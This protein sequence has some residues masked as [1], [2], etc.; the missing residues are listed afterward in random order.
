MATPKKLC[1]VHAQADTVQVGELAKRLQPLENRGD[2]ILWHLACVPAG[3]S[4]PKNFQAFF[5]E[6][7]AVLI[8]ISPDLWAEDGLYNL[9]RQQTN[10]PRII[11]VLARSVVWD[12]D[13]FLKKHAK[14]LLPVTRQPMPTDDPARQDAWFSA[15]VDG[16]TVELGLRVLE[17]S[18]SPE[19]WK[20]WPFWAWAIPVLIS[21]VGLFFAYPSYK[22]D[23]QEIEAR[24]AARNQSTPPPDPGCGFPAQ[25]DSTH[26]YVLITRFEDY[27]N[28]NTTECYGRGIESRIDLVKNRE[29][30]PIKFCYV[31][32]LS[33]NQSDEAARLR[34]R[35]HADLVI[36]GKLR[37]AS[38]DCRADG[39][40]LNYQP[41]DTL[42]RYAGGQ[43]PKK[44]DNEYMLDVTATDL[45]EGM[46]NLGEESFDSWLLSM[47]N[48]KVGKQK[49]AFYRIAADWPAVRKAMEYGKRAEMYFALGLWNNTI[50][51][52]S[53]CI[54][55]KPEFIYYYKRGVAKANL[56]QNSEAIEDFNQA[57]LYKKDDTN[58]L[59]N[60]GKGNWMMGREEDAI[61]DLNR[62]IELD[63]NYSLAYNLRGVIKD[64]TGNI[65]AA[66]LDYNKAIRLNPNYAYAYVNRGAAKIAIGQIQE[67]IDDY[68]LAINLDPNNATAFNNRA[69]AKNQLGF[70]IEA[71]QDYDKAIQF[72][73]NDPWFYF[74]RGMTKIK[75]GYYQGA[76]DDLDKTLEM[77]STNGPALINRGFA[78][79]KIKLYQE[80][81]LD[82]NKA[83]RLNSKKADAY[84][85]RGVTYINLD[86]PK[87]AIAD[88]SK[89]IE[90]DSSNALIF[91][92]RGML[93]IGFGNYELAISDFNKAI[94][95]DP[96]SALC[97]L[98]RGVAKNKLGQYR[99]SIPDFNQAIRLYP[100]YID[101]YTNR[102]DAYRKL[103]R[104]PQAWLD[105]F[106]VF[107]L[108]RLPGWRLYVIFSPLI[109]LGLLYYFRKRV[110]S[111]LRWFRQKQ[112]K[113]IFRKKQLR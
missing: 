66:I 29:N 53:Q 113:R 80:A 56:G 59:Y 27:S 95:L 41:S 100:T 5:A 89:A 71:I 4:I 75:L 42:I 7:D 68:N 101:A 96:N 55:L 109:L 79:G 83:I 57:G 82:L 65:Q 99:N 30:L 97:L 1:I 38:A 26:L 21:L 107:H 28:E 17:T 78:K 98:N 25:F 60:R 48:L 19:F 72:N 13:D 8:W 39:L 84:A 93:H 63:S 14:A 15:V 67:G 85:N 16:L 110:V 102:A 81:I 70:S 61:S 64:H 87:E 62:L 22:A 103:G 9:F 86:K 20:K 76:I 35:Y 52:Y 3:D 44:V 47:S 31:D 105:D 58:L 77:D 12:S 108:Q 11:P 104:Y 49:P 51:D 32:S 73:P 106:Q 46:I 111:Q 88:F 10:S 18:A 90:L 74:N 50:T 23:T 33:P 112:Q 24:E 2:V 94:N 91:S 36:W 69:S 37:N 92:N 6:A 40:C 34:D 45:E 43:V 54:R